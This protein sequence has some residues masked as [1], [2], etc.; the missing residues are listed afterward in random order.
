M[1]CMIHAINLDVQDGSLLSCG[2]VHALYDMSE[3]GSRE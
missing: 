2:A 3:V 1:I